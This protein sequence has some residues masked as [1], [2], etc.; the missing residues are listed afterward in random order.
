MLQKIYIHEFAK[1]QLKDY[2]RLSEFKNG[3]SIKDQKFLKVMKE[4]TIL[5][6]GHYQILLPLKG[7]D[8]NLQKTGNK[9][10]SDL[11]G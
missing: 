2:I 11:K 9:Q 8:V 10:K 4:N 5:V 6:N 7:P 1:P 3:I